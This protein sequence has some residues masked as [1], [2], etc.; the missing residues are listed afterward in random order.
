[1]MTLNPYGWLLALRHL[2]FDKGWVR[3]VSFP[4]PVICVGGLTAGGTG[5][6]PMI[7]YLVGHCLAQGRVPVVLSRGYKRTT[8]GFRLVHP[9]DDYSTVGDEPL[10]IKRRYPTVTVA[11]DANR[12]RGIGRLRQAG[13]PFDVVLLDDAF[14][15]RRLNA[16]CN[17]LLENF[18]R[19]VAH[20]RL[21]PF[22]RLRDLPGAARR[23]HCIIVTKC[24]PDFA[25]SA[26]STSPDGIPMFYASASYTMQPSLAAGTP[27]LLVTGIAHPQ[28]VATALQ[29]LY[30]I[31]AHRFFNDHHAYTAR[32][33]AS[34]QELARQKNATLVTTEKD[35]VRLKVEPL[36][37]WRMTFNEPYNHSQ[38]FTYFLASFLS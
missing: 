6:T 14:Q 8:K 21:I 26:P 20:D 23:A 15:Y 12:V 36:H 28:P 32:Q 9:N 1:M 22:G 3:S 18:H 38:L 13:V 35:A 24:P 27:I 2:L 19:P 17:I 16:S 11:V 10:Q 29:P 4:F 5:K 31:T 30:P 7:E 33:T 34:L 25:S 37:V